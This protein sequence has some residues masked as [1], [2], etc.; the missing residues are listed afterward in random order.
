MAEMTL[1]IT[2]AYPCKCYE[3]E[4]VNWSLAKV[5]DTLADHKK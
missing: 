1:A 2:Y 3:R 5:T 4:A